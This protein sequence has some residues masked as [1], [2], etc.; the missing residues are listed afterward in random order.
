MHSQNLLDIVIN[1]YYYIV[2]PDLYRTVAS[3][4]NS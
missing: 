1:L 3:T 4:L 2:R